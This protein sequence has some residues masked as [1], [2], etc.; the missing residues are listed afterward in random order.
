M[1]RQIQM[2]PQVSVAD[3]KAKLKAVHKDR[4]RAQWLVMYNAMLAPSPA[5]T[6]ALHTATS[7]WLVSHTISQYPRWGPVSIEEDHRGGRHL[8]S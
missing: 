1:S 3:V 6:L 5:E 2:T 4:Q 7:L 8:P